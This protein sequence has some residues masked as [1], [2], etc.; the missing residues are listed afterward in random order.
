MV[1]SICYIVYGIL[2]MIYIY[3]FKIE[4]GEGVDMGLG[5]HK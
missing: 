3:I 4:G 5:P 2:Y 1:F